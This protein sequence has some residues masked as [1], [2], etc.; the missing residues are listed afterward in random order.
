MHS[1]IHEIC[2]VGIAWWVYWYKRDGYGVWGE[3][4]GVADRWQDNSI[5]G[6]QYIID[7]ISTKVLSDIHVTTCNGVIIDIW[8][9]DQTTAGTHLL[10][11]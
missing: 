6:T 3:K 9:T 11:I 5:A 1:F 2:L 4:G 8:E 7:N 10:C